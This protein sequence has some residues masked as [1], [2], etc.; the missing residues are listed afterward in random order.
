MAAVAAVV[1][2]RRNRLK[3]SGGKS[4]EAEDGAERRRRFAQKL[5]TDQRRAAELFDE[6][7]EHCHGAP[8]RHLGHVR[9]V[10][11]AFVAMA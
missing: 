9:S 8:R 10:L 5:A 6:L 1:A 3:K 11:A 2:A 4:T 7:D